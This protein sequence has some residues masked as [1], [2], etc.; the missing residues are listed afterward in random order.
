MALLIFVAKTLCNQA[1]FPSMD[2]F[3]SFLKNNLN[4][5][6]SQTKNKTQ[7][8]KKQ[9]KQKELNTQKHTKEKC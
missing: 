8:K 3:E 5:H 2:F 1:L 6:A 4:T 9:A 7:N